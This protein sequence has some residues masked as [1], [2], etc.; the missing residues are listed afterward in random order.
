MNGCDV[1]RFWGV[2]FTDVVVWYEIECGGR[3]GDG[4]CF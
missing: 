2:D 4:L 3:W 1:L